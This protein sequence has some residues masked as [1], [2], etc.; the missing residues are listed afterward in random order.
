MKLV[1]MYRLRRL[2]TRIT[3]IVIFTFYTFIS[4]MVWDRFFTNIA[5]CLFNLLIEIQLVLFPEY[6]LVLR[7]IHFKRSNIRLNY[8]FCKIFLTLRPV[9]ILEIVDIFK[10][11]ANKIKT[12]IIK[13]VIFTKL[14]LLLFKTLIEHQI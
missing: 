6:L 8:C 12:V 14:L 7:A 3:K 11:S 4:R 2:I 1:R 9:L 5:R 13:L 10:K